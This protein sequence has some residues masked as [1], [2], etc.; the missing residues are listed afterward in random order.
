MEFRS[1]NILERETLLFILVLDVGYHG[2]S[3][4]R[5][6]SSRATIAA[7]CRVV[8]TLGW[9]RDERFGTSRSSLIHPGG[10]YGP[11]SLRQR[12]SVTR[13]RLRSLTPTWRPTPPSLEEVNMGLARV[14]TLAQVGRRASC[15]VGVGVGIAR[16]SRF[17]CLT[18]FPPLL[19]SST[20]PQLLR[21]PRVNQGA[22]RFAE[23]S[24]PPNGSLFI[25][26]T[27]GFF[28]EILPTWI[29]LQP[30]GN[31]PPRVSTVN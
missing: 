3:L 27:L 1:L 10:I 4:Q 19:I 28:H 16:V 12:S 21:L 31:F 30:F 26:G 7:D 11:S 18:C 13:S 6:K 9:I 24:P 2:N 5:K 8:W 23:L 20:R 17:Q 25:K 14:G 22:I 15:V 29:W